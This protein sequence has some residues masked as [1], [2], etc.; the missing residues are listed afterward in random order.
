MSKTGKVIRKGGYLPM[1]ELSPDHPIY[2]RG[3]VVGKS[4][5]TPSSKSTAKGMSSSKA[6]DF[7]DFLRRSDEQIGKEL[8]AQM[9]GDYPS[10]KTGE[11]GSSTGAKPKGEKS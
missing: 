11:S 2:K 1:T 6:E 8:R 9:S 5:L 10:A 4:S 7:Q 3:F